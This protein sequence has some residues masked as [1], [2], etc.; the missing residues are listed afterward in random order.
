MRRGGIIKEELMEKC[1]CENFSPVY[2]G[3]SAQCDLSLSPLSFS[4]DCL[5]IVHSL[6]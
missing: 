6:S 4:S 3:F 1:K 5:A 2:P